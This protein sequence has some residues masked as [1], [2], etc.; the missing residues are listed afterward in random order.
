MK[1]FLTKEEW[2]IL[3]KILKSNKIRHSRLGWFGQV[4]GDTTIP[5][6]SIMIY[7]ELKDLIRFIK[8]QKIPK[9][10]KK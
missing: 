1:L 8:N 7:G 6:Y 2:E 4:F 5:E 9:K 3:F 10:L